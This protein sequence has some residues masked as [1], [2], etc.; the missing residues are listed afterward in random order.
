MAKQRELFTQGAV[1]KGFEQELASNIFDLMEK[2]AGY[3]FNKSHSAAYALVAYQTGWLKAHYPA[4]FMAATISSDMD[5]TDKVVTFIDECRAMGLDL[6][7]PDVNNGQFH[8]SVDIQGRVLYGLGAIKGLGEGPVEN[9]IAARTEGGPF[10]D[11]FDFCARVDGRK[12]NKRALEAMI[13]SGALDE[14]GPEGEI[15][16]RRAV[17]LAGMDEAVKLAEQHARNTSSGMG[18]LFGDSIVDSASDINYNSYSAARTLSVRDRLN[19]EKETLGL[20]LTGHPIDE[21]E[22]EL[23]QMLPNRIADLRPGKETSS[24]SGM[25]VGM[26]IMKNKRG[27]SFAFLT[28][29]DKSGRIELSV[30]AEKFNAYREILVK[31]ALLVVQGNVSE[32]SF[33]GGLKMVAESIQS[34]YEARCSKLSRLE[35][36]LNGGSESSGWVDKF[37]HTLSGY[38]E[39]NCPV[40]VQYALPSASGQLKLGDQWKVQP[41]DELISRLREEFGKN[42]VTLHY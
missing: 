30:W 15:G 31:D 1:N 23:K 12:V 8:F 40:T 36:C 2:F 5:K 42:S 39:G 22:D 13:R 26:R 35:L 37:H 28:L 6:L 21:Y 17:M 32:D 4:E 11:M 33:T 16:F 20:Y 25:V 27:D 19:G 18:D 34:I 14:I 29:D 24:I 3:G 9:I 7:P 41:K 38:K 10:K